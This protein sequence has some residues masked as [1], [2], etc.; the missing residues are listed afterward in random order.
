[1]KSSLP[2]QYIGYYLEKVFGSEIEYQ[3]QF[4]WLGRYSLDIYIPSLQLA[5]EYDGIYY[6]AYKSTTDNL[7]TSW[8]R[9][10]GIF[11]IHI[12]EKKL[13]NP[14]VESEMK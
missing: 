9:S 13:I 1:M 3:K 8:C 7:K 2:E 14:K 12:V 10:H 5:I 6:H 4:D 11:L